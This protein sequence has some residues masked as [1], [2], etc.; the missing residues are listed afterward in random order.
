MTSYGNVSTKPFSPYDYNEYSAADHGGSVFL[1][2]TAHDSEDRLEITIDTSLTM[3]SGDFTYEAWVYLYS[4]DVTKEASLFSARSSGYES[5]ILK[6][7]NHGTEG[8]NLLIANS[9]GSSW[10]VLNSKGGAVF[11]NVWTHVA[12]VRNGTSIKVYTNG[13]EAQSH[14]FSGSLNEDNNTLYIGYDADSRYGLG[15]VSD[16]RITKGT[17][18]YTA[19]FIPPTAPPSSTGASL[20]IK[21]TDA[22]II[23]KSQGSN[24]K[25]FGNT[26]GST[27]Q[28]KF[29]GSKSMYFD[30][31]GD[32]I[33][34]ENNSNFNLGTGALTVELWY[35]LANSQTHTI[36][37]L[38]D[39]YP[40]GGG[41]LY[42]NNRAKMAITS[43]KI[44]LND[45]TANICNYA[46][47]QVINQWRHWAWSRDA[48]GNNR[49]YLNGNQIGT[50]TSSSNN[51][52]TPIVDLGRRAETGGSYMQGYIQDFRIT[53]G[54]A[55]YTAN[56]TPPTAPLEG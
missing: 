15:H 42:T 18:V 29:G 49:F 43:T 25:L 30:G 12:I 35:Y 2:G 28:A 20:H 56:F 53:K 21:G 11:A 39:G 50:T 51:L 8:T 46:E 55:R 24:L 32:Y 9:A 16:V 52:I 17:A 4:E 37:E 40:N 23:D 26:T 44:L 19:E 1:G 7:R 33:T 47:T 27:T 14:T 54:L 36:F 45:G 38:H 6:V 34:T 48:S 41:T 10:S 31:S 22:S 3:G 5:F 13:K